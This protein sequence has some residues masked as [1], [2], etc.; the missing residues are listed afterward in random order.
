MC[1]IGGMILKNEEVAPRALEIM[2]DAM[3]HRGPDGRGVYA[4]KTLGWRT[5]VSP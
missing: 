2:C 3:A 5:H 4:K 1:G